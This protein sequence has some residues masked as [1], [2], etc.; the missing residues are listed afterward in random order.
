[1]AKYKRADV[2]GDEDTS[3]YS[4]EVAKERDAKPADE[5]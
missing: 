1:M 5:S 4:Q 3:T 2:L